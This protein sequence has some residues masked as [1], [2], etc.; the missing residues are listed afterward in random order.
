[1][2]TGTAGGTDLTIQP[3]PT[4]FEGLTEYSVRISND[5]VQ[6]LAT[7]PNLFAGISDDTTWAFTTVDL[8]RVVIQPSNAVASSEYSGR[9]AIDAINS[10]GIDGTLI[11]TLDPIPYPWPA[12]NTVKTDCWMTDNVGSSEISNQ[13]LA[14]DLGDFYDVDGV[15]VWHYS[16]GG[17]AANGVQHLDVLFAAS[18]SDTFGSGA[19]ISNDYYG[20]IS[21]TSSAATSGHPGQFIG[22]DPPVAARYVLLD[23]TSNYGSSYVGLAEVRFTGR[24]YVEPPSGSALVVR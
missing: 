14:V 13:W 6:D 1:M 3:P 7:T 5:A 19:S 16:D 21:K 20:A 23:I 18:L 22:F 2:Q 12:A 9:P 10:T 8:E 11:E 4:G 24:T 15:Y 17:N